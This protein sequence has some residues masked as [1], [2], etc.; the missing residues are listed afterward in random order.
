MAVCG[1]SSGGGE[2]GSVGDDEDEDRACRAAD[3]TEMDVFER[4]TA[5]GTTAL[6]SVVDVVDADARFGS[7]GD[8][9]H[10]EASGDGDVVGVRVVGFDESDG[11]LGGTTD[12]SR[13]AAVADAVALARVLA[14]VVLLWVPWWRGWCVVVAVVV[15]V[16]VVVVVVASEPEV[17]WGGGGGSRGDG[18]AAGAR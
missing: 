10:G 12:R 11:L 14:A 7:G 6:A 2:E 1:K 9:L 3:E 4:G 8:V 5:A 16:V 15:A 13:V 18:G 17:I